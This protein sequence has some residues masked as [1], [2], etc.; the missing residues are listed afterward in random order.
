MKGD[1]NM[2]RFLNDTF[3]KSIHPINDITSPYQDLGLVV[4]GLNMA[5]GA[6][7]YSEYYDSVE[8]VRNVFA[9]ATSDQQYNIGL[10]RRDTSGQS[11][12]GA[13]WATNQA[14]PAGGTYRGH[15]LPASGT[16]GHGLLGKSA[17]FYIQNTST[18]SNTYARLRVQLFGL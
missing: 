14:A 17:A 6:V 1:E 12:F 2:T 4:E 8:W 18:V 15:P 10:R 3:I 11:D 5:A 16:S 9:M 13:A 7:V